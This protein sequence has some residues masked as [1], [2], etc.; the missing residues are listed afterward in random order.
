MSIELA[1]V[2]NPGGFAVNRGKKCIDSDDHGVRITYMRGSRQ[3]FS[4]AFSLIEL[5]VVISIIALLISLLLPALARTRRMGQS[6]VCGSNQR[7]VLQGMH[8]YHISERNIPA[9]TRAH[10]ATPPF[11]TDS[12]LF[13]PT[14]LSAAVWHATASK[15]LF[16]NFGVI[17]QARMYDSPQVFYCPAQ[18]HPVFQ[19]DTDP[20]PWEFDPNGH[21]I[22]NGDGFKLWS[23]VFTSYTRRLGLSKLQFDQLHPGVAIIAD[24]NMQPVYVR[25]HHNAEGFNYATLDGAVTWTN[26]PWFKDDASLED[27][28][29]PDY[30]DVARHALKV[31]RRLDRAGVPDDWWK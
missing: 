8:N 9:L 18:S 12:E 31:F 2:I 16:V 21:T 24:V 26:D 30:A 28:S 5:L 10:D 22:S 25:T 4:P 23:D 29:G 6:A 13:V 15:S 11:Q 3:S 14:W 20:N 27:T 1:G 7:Q 17:W 19:Y